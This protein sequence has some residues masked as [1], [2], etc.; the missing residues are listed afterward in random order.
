MILKHVHQTLNN[1]SNTCIIY[2]LRFYMCTIKSAEIKTKSV[3]ISDLDGTGHNSSYRKIHHHIIS[4]PHFK[5][6][7]FNSN[8]I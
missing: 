5:L 7:S 6:L 1:P 8:F 4:L 2:A 3:K